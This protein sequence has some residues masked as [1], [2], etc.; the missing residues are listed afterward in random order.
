[1]QAFREQVATAV[2]S[3]DFDAASLASQ[4]PE[5]FQAFASEN[6]IDMAEFLTQLSSRAGHA[7]ESST[8]ASASSS[9]K[10]AESASVYEAS[11]SYQ[12]I[13]DIIDQLGGNQQPDGIV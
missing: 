11:N 6:G 8:Q 12:K 2:D 5:E 9:L 7:G 4:A 13:S 1:M 3:G 10:G